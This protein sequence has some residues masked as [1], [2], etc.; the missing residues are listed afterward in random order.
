MSVVKNPFLLL[1]VAEQLP[2]VNFVM[3]G[4]GELYEAVRGIAPLNV[5]VIGW[6]NA[7]I[8]W[9][10]VDCAIST[11]DSEGMPVA[12]I[13]AQFAGLPVIATNVGSN[14]ELIVS[15]KTGLITTKSGPDLVAA[16]GTLLSNHG[17]LV[18]MGEQ[19]KIRANSKFGIDKMLSKHQE[20][21]DKLLQDIQE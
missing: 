4:G 19:A 2:D 18:A 15:G 16:V 20:M 11:S 8:F 21:Y 9:S 17:L 7:E 13:E 12:L 1:E 3:A 5:A 6:S 14:Q 10:A